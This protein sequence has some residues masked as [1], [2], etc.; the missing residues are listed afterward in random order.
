MSLLNRTVLML[1]GIERMQESCR[2]AWGQTDDRRLKAI[3]LQIV[4][5]LEQP[6]MLLEMAKDVLERK[7]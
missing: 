5:D 6:K 2:E 4:G 3:Y 7:K 1:K